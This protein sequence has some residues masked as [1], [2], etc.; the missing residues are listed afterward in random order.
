M[1][2]KLSVVSCVLGADLRNHFLIKSNICTVWALS[3]R[4]SPRLEVIVVCG[5]RKVPALIPLLL[6][7][8][9]SWHHSFHVNYLG[10]FVE[11]HWAMN[12]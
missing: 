2:S 6:N 5:V 10:I 7:I 3:F 1:N 4:S 11:N 12:G 9:L 8:Q